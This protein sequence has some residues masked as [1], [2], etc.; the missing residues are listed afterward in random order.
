MRVVVIGSGIGGLSAAVALSARGAEVTVLEQADA[1]GGKMRDL[2]TAAGP[3]AAGPT[4][5]A[6]RS[7]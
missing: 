3:A 7:T 1:P 2:P 4:R 5:E 6:A